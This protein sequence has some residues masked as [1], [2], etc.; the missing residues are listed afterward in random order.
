MEKKLK[1]E[2]TIAQIRKMKTIRTLPSGKEKEE[3]KTIL[4]MKG[5][6]LRIL[7]VSK[8][9]KQTE[10]MGDLRATCQA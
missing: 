9:T 2:T 6:T 5:V 4:H 1:Q 7:R 3:K 10:Q 8:I